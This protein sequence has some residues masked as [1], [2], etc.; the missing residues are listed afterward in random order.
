[1][2]P[3]AG[4]LVLDY[5]WSSVYWTISWLRRI[6]AGGSRHLHWVVALAISFDLR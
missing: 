1:L 3:C 5:T 6:H 2:G 4:M